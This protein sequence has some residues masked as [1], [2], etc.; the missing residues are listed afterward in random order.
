[1]SVSN[2]KRI[3]V[4]LVRHEREVE[5]EQE[6]TSLRIQIEILKQEVNEL[7]NKSGYE[8]TLNNILIDILRENHIPFRPSLELAKR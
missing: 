8:S 4:E 2:N 7:A 3:I 5:L 1:M 6:I